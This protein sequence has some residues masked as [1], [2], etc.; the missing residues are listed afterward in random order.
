[1]QTQTLE[2]SLDNELQEGEEVLWSGRPDPQRRRIVYPTKVFVVLG[3]IF[4]PV[5]LFIVLVGLVLLLLSVF[6]P[7]ARLASLGV[8]I[9]GGVF[10]L[11]GIIYFLIGLV[12]SSTPRNT[13]YAITNRRVII[14]RPGHYLR[15]TSYGRGAITQVQ[16]FERSDG[17]GDLVFA[18]TPANGSPGRNRSNAGFSSAIHPGVFSALPNVR[19]VEQ[20]LTR[21]LNEG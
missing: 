19:Q 2:A 10:V 8:F 6:P 12:G 18:T 4:M 11:L 21:M 5:G 13:L 20:I 1:M 7:E 9:P 3:L 16:R 17:S 15:V 14:L